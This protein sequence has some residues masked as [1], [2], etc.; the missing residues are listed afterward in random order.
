MRS[1]AIQ[2]AKVAGRSGGETRSIATPAEPAKFQR[3][4]SGRS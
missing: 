1:V 3:P 2:L 4:S